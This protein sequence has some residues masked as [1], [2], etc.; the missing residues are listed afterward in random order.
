[1]TQPS[2]YLVFATAAFKIA[3]AIDHKGVLIVLRALPNEHNVS[4]IAHYK[5]G[6][7]GQI[8]CLNENLETIHSML[9][10]VPDPSQY[11][12]QAIA[13]FNN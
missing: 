13:I 6:D 2:A 3:K 8:L 9:A 10:G 5:V 7:I 4:Y 11:E 1:M 12:G